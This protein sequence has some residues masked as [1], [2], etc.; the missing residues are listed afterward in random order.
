MNDRKIYI[1]RDDILTGVLD[2]N[3]RVKSTF[4]GQMYMDANNNLY[5]SLE[6]NNTRWTYLLSSEEEITFDELMEK[7]NSKV[8]DVKVEVVDGKEV[9]KLYSNGNLLLEVPLGNADAFDG[10]Y[11]ANDNDGNKVLYFTANNEVKHTVN[12]GRIDTKFD[13]AAIT[14]NASESE[15]Y[16]ELMVGDET[17][18]KLTLPA[19]GGGTGTLLPTLTSDY[20]ELTMGGVD[21][22]YEIN[23]F[24]TSP[25]IGKGTAYYYVDNEEST[26]EI[27]Q[28]DNKFTVGPLPKGEHTVRISV[29]DVAGA[30]SN[31]L[32]FR[33]ISGGLEVTSTFDD[34]D[35][36]E[37]DNYV[38]IDYNIASI[39]PDQTYHCELTLDGQT[40]LL[41][42]IDLGAH[43]WDIGMLDKGVHKATIRAYSAKLESNVL[44]FSLVVTDT[45]SLY[46]S[47]TFSETQME[48]G[49]V[50]LVDYRISMK[51]M[52]KFLVYFYIDGDEVMQGEADLGTNFWSVGEL[53]IGQHT[54][55]IKAT[56]LDGLVESNTLQIPLEIVAFN[57]TPLEIVQDGLVFNFDGRDNNN[58]SLTNNVWKDRTTNNVECKLHNFNFVGNGW[59]GESLK[60]NGDAYAEINY[61]PFDNALKN[62]MTLEIK[63]KVENIG[64]LDARVIDCALQKT[65][66]T[67]L[68]IDTQEAVFSSALKSVA[69]N[70]P[71]NRFNSMS[72][73]IDRELGLMA[74]YAN[75]V[76]TKVGWLADNESFAMN[77]TIFLGGRT[78]DSFTTKYLDASHM[79]IG[80]ID[81][82]GALVDDL[83][84]VTTKD[85]IAGAGA[86]TIEMTNSTSVIDSIH[87]Y[88][89]ERYID[90][91]NNVMN[92]IYTI[93][94]PATAT[95]MKISFR[96]ID[97]GTI[98]LNNA[99]ALVRKS[100]DDILNS[101]SC[102]IQSVRMYN[103]GLS[104]TEIVNNY[105]ADEHNPDAQTALRHLNYDA[106]G[107]PSMY[108]YGDPTGMTKDDRVQMRIR[109]IDPMDPSKSFD[110]LNC[111]VQWQGTSSLA[112][113]VKNYKIRLFAEDDINTKEYRKIKDDW[114]PE[115][116]FTLKADYMESSHQSNTGMC[117]FYSDYYNEPNPSQKMQPKVRNQ[118]DGFPMLLYINGRL[119]GIYNFNLDKG[120]I[121]L[122]YEQF[123]SANEYF[124]SNG[125]YDAYKAGGGDMELNDWLKDQG[126][127]EVVDP[128]Y[129]GYNKKKHVK[130]NTLALSEDLDDSMD[131]LKVAPQGTVVGDLLYENP[132]VMSYEIAAN[133]DT[134]AGA[135]ASSEWNS[136][137]SEFEIRFHPEEDDVINEDETLKEGCHPELVRLVEWVMNA[138]DETFKAEFDQ[139]WNFEYT[140]KYF[141]S[142]FTFGMVDNLGK[143]LM[144][145]TWDGK[146]WYPQFYDL[147]SQLGSDNTGFLRFGP[148]VDFL[149]DRSQRHEMADDYGLD[150]GAQSGDY[151]T[152]NSRLWTK[153]QRC[154]AQE[155]KEMYFELRRGMFTP[156]NV[157]N[158]LITNGTDTIAQTQFNYDAIQKYLPYGDEYIHML[159]GSKEGHLRKWIYERFIYMDSVFEFGNYTVKQCTVRANKLGVVKLR[160]RSYSPLYVKIVFSGATG[161][162]EKRLVTAD[163][164]T[165]FTGYVATT[166]DNEINI[167]GADNLM[168]ID[169]IR[170]LQPSVLLLTQCEK[171]VELDCSGSQHMR[172]LQLANNRLL[173]KLVC[174]NCVYLGDTTSGG[175]PELNLSGSQHI[176]YL[177][178][179]DTM[180]SSVIFGTGGALKYC[181]L[182]NTRIREVNMAGQQ[183]LPSL[184]LANCPELATVNLS[185]CNKLRTLNL[186][187]TNLSVVSINNCD[188]LEVIDLS[189]TPN[190]NSLDLTGCPA[191]KDLKV[192]GVINNKITEL[193]LSYCENLQYLDISNCAYVTN[194]RFSTNYD[195]LISF[196]AANSGITA[197]RFGTATAAG[198]LDLTRFELSEVNFYNCTNV[199]DIRG[200]YLDA[201]NASPFYNC[202]NLVRI[203]GEVKLSGSANQAFY[204]CEKLESFPEMDLSGATLLNE[205]FR[206]CKLMNRETF[207]N[208]I[209]QLV[210]ARTLYQTFNGCIGIIYSVDEDFPADL[211]SALEKVE[212]FSHV[213]D[214]C[215]NMQMKRIPSGIFKPMILVE[216]LKYPFCNGTVHGNITGDLLHYNSLL[217]EVD[218]L[219]DHQSNMSGTIPSTLFASCPNLTSVR[220]AF[221]SAYGLT[222]EIPG[223]LFSNNPNLVN[224]SDCFSGTRGLS[225]S[226]PANLF[227]NCPKLVNARWCFENSGIGGNIPENLFANCPV[228][229]NIGYLFSNTQ[230]N[231]PLPAGFIKNKKSLVNVDRMFENCN[232]GGEEDNFNEFPADFFEGLTALQSANYCF[233]GC[234]NLKFTLPAGLFKDCINLK[235]IDYLFYN[236]KGIRGGLNSNIFVING[237]AYTNAVSVLEG[238]SGISGNIPEDFFEP[239]INVKD[240]SGFFSGCAGIT[241]VIP[242]AL[243][244][245]C[246]NLI[247]ANRLF[248]GTGLGKHRVDADD[249]YFIDPNFFRYNVYLE[250]IDG[251]FDAADA[252]R[253]LIGAIPPDLFRYNVNLIDAGSLFA[254]CTG[255]TGELNGAHFRY[256]AKLQDVSNMFYNS[257]IT[258]I[259]NDVFN[260]TNNPVMNDFTATFKGLNNLTGTAPA[261]WD[262][263]PGAAR[264]ECFLNCNNLTNFAAIPDSW[265]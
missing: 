234:R 112:Y 35:D 5:Y 242:T 152:S 82:G 203:V 142:T 36:L 121:T 260:T 44:E 119:E 117:R 255:I 129:P 51:D 166:R 180:L 184:E 161:N 49:K 94:V 245:N 60:F 199:V 56:T 7:V 90:S 73:V 68:Y 204:G 167:Y 185:E 196:N 162:V 10:I 58:A 143:N 6:A 80:A 209:K 224:V 11:A 113:A 256:N 208:I 17:K 107:M 93:D 84:V 248:K 264:N 105:I 207:E 102:E 189:H 34:S 18:C 126:A 47:T 187:A 227:A 22:I 131:K 55:A 186:P 101:A 28:G 46:V 120:A 197:F 206:G 243:L 191:L 212:E 194:I 145:T 200:I 170:D 39:D 155:I 160:L 179:S 233:S 89:G 24:F 249:P 151:N 158:H 54:L 109:Y 1:N 217:E 132:H 156:E 114:F 150:N 205:T 169:G 229:E 14:T 115:T 4:K 168:Y 106:D 31:Q 139:Y 148:S 61:A 265:K 99:T 43:S 165:E 104:H 19:G 59:Q 253:N 42:D 40:T 231:G 183:H 225:G 27:R 63:Y 146:V 157:I 147:D 110:K 149:V 211:F 202:K 154:F 159:N 174:K 57:F 232:I 250:E 124:N 13:G 30:F 144:I 15:F 172:S 33:I 64:D 213:F 173:Q 216:R 247:Y 177:D 9:L 153:F 83:Y 78:D 251:M 138:D 74:I 100:D 76:L 92:N 38:V 53:A 41:E 16:L 222:G 70:A 223:T 12:L 176:K 133:S 98:G 3:G 50:P 226:V 48:F 136:I 238:C 218:G 140:C 239:F 181:N 259:T 175:N 135:F 87:F 262:M 95:G 128:N 72:F 81:N 236:C 263:Y 261:L 108:F 192:T 219:F 220:G 195:K 193:D 240:L 163:G 75:G 190:L 201:N 122:G 210:N 71:E 171:L 8:D 37:L 111:K 257:S 26:A 244:Q 198:Y 214:D 88:N 45:T 91:I 69:V 67:G 137:S 230:I 85:L 254:N 228:I 134:G 62:G 77:K 221:L 188:E 103:R 178:A 25:N 141:L 97:G 2:P 127:L 32:T 118:I 65:P 20:P 252:P 241:G 246:T 130:I 116:V 164:F 79:T 23:Y 182:S 237:G 21:D 125:E 235:S 66:F 86:F 52:K 29:I 215:I 258:S 123:L 96:R